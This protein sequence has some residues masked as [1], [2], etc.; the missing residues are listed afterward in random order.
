[1]LKDFFITENFVKCY[2]LV[3]NFNAFHCVIAMK[4]ITRNETVIYYAKKTS[5]IKK[6]IHYCNAE[7]D[8]SHRKKKNKNFI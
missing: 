8:I 2:Y 3:W 1:M 6:K 4:N 7:W 5:S